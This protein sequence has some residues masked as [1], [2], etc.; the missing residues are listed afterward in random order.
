MRPSHRIHVYKTG[1]MNRLLHN[2][3]NGYPWYYSGTVPAD[4][5]MSFIAHLEEEYAVDASEDRRQYRRRRHGQANAFVQLHPSYTSPF[6]HWW[7]QLTDGTH[8]EPVPPSLLA[9]ARARGGTVSSFQETSRPCSAQLR[10]ASPAGPG[11]SPA[12]PI[13]TTPSEF[14]L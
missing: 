12:P 1:L 4:R 10:A 7:L 3:L 11:N 8:P 5:V 14:A 13:K 6:F 2:M 9:D